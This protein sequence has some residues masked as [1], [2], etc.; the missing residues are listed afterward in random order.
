MRAVD[1]KVSIPSIGRARKTLARA[2]TEWEKAKDDLESRRQVAEKGWRAAR[3]AVLAVF[4][5]HYGTPHRGPSGVPVFERN[6]LGRKEGK[7]GGQPLASE[8]QRA[9]STL[10]GKCFYGDTCP[11]RKD[12]RSELRQVGGLIDQ[13]EADVKT[14]ERRKR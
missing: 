1:V 8:F 6:V 4:Y 5:S 7:A 11:S 12:L 13:A 2:V 9:Q 10:H 3:E 14:I